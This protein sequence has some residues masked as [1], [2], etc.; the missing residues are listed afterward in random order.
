MKIICQQNNSGFGQLSVIFF[1]SINRK[2]GKKQTESK[3]V[4]GEVGMKLV[5]AKL[6]QILFALCE[7]VIKPHN[8]SHYANATHKQHK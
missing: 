2:T 1:R 6:G 3:K 7:E 8:I 4:A 5:K